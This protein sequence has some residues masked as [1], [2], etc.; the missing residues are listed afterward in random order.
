MMKLDDKTWS[1]LQETVWGHTVGILA[2]AANREGYPRPELGLSQGSGV[3]VEV[4]GVFLLATCAHT[5]SSLGDHYLV[6]PL[7]NETRRA[8]LTD[9]ILASEGRVKDLQPFNEPNS[10]DLAFIKIDPSRFLRDRHTFYSLNQEIPHL[11]TAIH[12][13]ACGAPGRMRTDTV[14]P[15]SARVVGPK[16]VRWGQL[17]IEPVWSDS[18]EQ[19]RDILRASMVDFDSGYLDRSGEV[20]S[21]PVS[22]GGLSGGGFWAFAASGPVL[23]GI[24]VFEDSTSMAAVNINLWRKFYLAQLRGAH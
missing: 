4:D 24:T 21:P 8:E 9:Y 22:W 15:T 18:G 17:R 10:N 3:L 16:V 11:D 7:T 5:L 13:I 20:L 6:L 12:V 1:K 2:F 14:T 23:I 19:I